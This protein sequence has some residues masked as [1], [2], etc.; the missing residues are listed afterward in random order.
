MGI[1]ARMLELLTSAYTK[2]DVR[3]L[4]KGLPLETNLGRVLSVLGWG[5][6]LIESNAEL[7]RLW[8]DLDHAAGSVLDRHGKNHGVPRGGTDDGFYR[9][10]IKTKLLSQISGGDIETILSAISSL[11]GIDPVNIELNEIFP[12]KVQVIL[13]EDDLPEEYSNIKDLVG[14]LT[15]RLLVAG[16]GIDMVYK[17]VAATSG[18]LAIGGRPT[19]EFT[20]IHLASKSWEPPLIRGELSI[21]GRPVSEFS[22]V[23]LSGAIKGGA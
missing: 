2:R 11:Y 18:S 9:L 3:N 7:V 5:L 14:S 12:A 15:K 19:S 22:R 17:D 23:R 1:T 21:G 13:A 10:L 20:R 6:G 8:A 4:R 16:V